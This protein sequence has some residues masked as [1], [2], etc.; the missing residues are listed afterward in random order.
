MRFLNPAAVVGAA[1]LLGA[2][3]SAGKPG[4]E[5]APGGGPAPVSGE[6]K[7][8][9]P[10]LPPIPL[11]EGK[12][13]LRVVY[14]TPEHVI[15]SRDSNFVMGSV[16]NG[17]ATLTI[18]GTPVPVAPNGAFLAFLPL[19]PR[20]TSRYDLVATAG[21][22][23]ASLAYVVKL[24]PPAVHFAPVGPLAYDSASVTPAPTARLA[25]RDDEMVRVSIRAPSNAAVLWRG[26]AG[27]GAPLV[28]GTA[29]LGAR[30]FG[31]PGATAPSWRAPGDAEQFAVDLPAKMLRAR[32]EL[33]IVR[34]DDTLHVLLGSVAPAPAPGTL[35]VLGADTSSVSDTDRTVIGR[36]LPAGTYKW[37]L[38]PGTV[39][40]VTGWNG[41][42]ARI[43]LDASLEIWVS[44]SEARLLPPGAPAPRRVTG[45][46]RLVP[47]PGWVDFVV[48]T[49]ARPAFFVEE[50]QRELTLTLYDTQLNTDL[51]HYG[52]N[53]SLVRMAQWTPDA[54]DRGHFT[55]RLASAPYGYLV[56]W[57]K[58]HN[59]LVLRVRRPPVV[60]P[61]SPL[62][63]MVIAV[64]PGHP[65]IGATGP[66][67]LY[68]PVPTLAIG[69]EVK[70]LLEA[71]GATVYM[72]RTT[73][74]PVGLNDRPVMIRRSNANAA[75]SIHLNA[76]PDG[77][78]P[79]ISNGTGAYYFWPQSIPLARELQLGMVS[80]MGLKNLGI[81]YDNLALARPT[82]MPAVLC[83][84]AF[85]M[86][87]DQESALRTPEFQTAYAR[88]VVDGL[89]RYF[90]SLATAK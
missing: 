34:G 31:T 7:S 4:A 56:M 32:T 66:T 21:A 88:G 75:V 18:N 40:P 89:E 65:P 85:L 12:L 84:G 71:D 61:S 49:G 52:E 83:E 25:L 47:A 9:A 22:D 80:R 41:D 37:F 10:A 72:T 78:N 5:T 16:G 51:I 11:V 33:L 28:N 53:D 15:E 58:D 67:G 19:P 46:A 6:A 54:S 38:F 64:D 82:W 69:M 76:L 68:E 73:A 14:P 36:P 70:R 26:D 29:P 43:R 42:F 59:S 23:T 44:A 81:N 62:K 3:A 13:A 17:H 79:F 87:P 2:C 77:V 1:W 48:P 24:P 90:R 50:G 57:D 35:V 30:L 20:E 74:D 63:G 39:V 27:A 86:L 45:Q 60:D 8:G 55:L